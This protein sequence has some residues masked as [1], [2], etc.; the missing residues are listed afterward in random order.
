MTDKLLEYERLEQEKKQIEAR[1]EHEKKQVD[2][3]L[4]RLKKDEEF[5]HDMEFK[6]QIEAVLET[7][8][9]KREDLLKLFGPATHDPSNKPVRRKASQKQPLKR[10]THPVTGKVVKARSLRNAT[11]QE[12]KREYDE[13]T[14]KSWG[15]VIEDD[16]SSS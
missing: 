14:V 12:W 9:K 5:Q 7:Y 3:K 8:E 11:L 1:C 2:A 6:Q 4:E 15:E 10:Y 13:D 16:F